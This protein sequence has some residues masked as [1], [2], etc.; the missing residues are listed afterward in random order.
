MDLVKGFQDIAVDKSRAGSPAPADGALDP[1][2]PGAMRS[3]GA[4]EPLAEL[5]AGRKKG[6]SS[7]AGRAVVE[8][9]AAELAVVAV[10]LELELVLQL[11]LAATPAVVPAVG[12]GV[13]LAVLLTLTVVEIVIAVVAVEIVIAMVAAEIVIEIVVAAAPA[14]VVVG[15]VAA[16]AAPLAAVDAGFGILRNGSV[17]VVAVHPLQHN[18][19]IVVLLVEAV[20]PVVVLAVA[21][22]FVVV[23]SA[24]LVAADPVECVDVGDDGDDGYVFGYMMVMMVP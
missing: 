8:V 5:E 17:E 22:L 3:F 2:T 11:V 9:P 16:A 24:L 21:D 6:T 15:V 18:A 12:L 19:E 14:A 23:I 13:E 7:A 20:V 10:G 4:V 1:P